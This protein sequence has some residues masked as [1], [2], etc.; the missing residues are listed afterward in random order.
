MNENRLISVMKW[1]IL[2][3]GIASLFMFYYD[4]FYNLHE[5]SSHPIFHK[6]HDRPE[7]E[8]APV[9]EN[10]NVKLLSVS[11]SQNKP[12]LDVTNKKETR[13]PSTP[14]SRDAVALLRD[15]PTKLSSTTPLSA[16]TLQKTIHETSKANGTFYSAQEI[17]EGVIIGKRGT[18][19][20]HADFYKIRAKGSMMTLKLEPSSK[21]RNHVFIMTVCDANQRVI[22]ESSEKM[23]RTINLKVTPQSTYYIKMDL[24]R[25]PIET[26]PYKLILFFK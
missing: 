24:N 18:A 4:T 21:N 12:K 10:H 1:G 17:N 14:D 15:Q 13:D 3:L 6:S 8:S 7:E 19:S 11:A 9:S 20:D 22:L 16:K 25:V 5:G 2:V 23:N 26:H